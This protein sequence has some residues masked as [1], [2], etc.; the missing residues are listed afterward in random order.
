MCEE[1]VHELKDNGCDC[2]T[3][4]EFKSGY[5]VDGKCGQ[6]IEACDP[7]TYTDHDGCSCVNGYVVCE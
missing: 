4:A 7:D 2:T 3:N 1:E 5:C 6:G